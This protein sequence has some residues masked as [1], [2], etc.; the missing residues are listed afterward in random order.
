MQGPFAGSIPS[1]K[2]L[3]DTGEV[4]LAL[5][6]N[7]EPLSRDHG[8]PVRA[9]VPGYNAAR[10]VK[11]GF[12]GLWGCGAVGLWGCGAVELWGCMQSVSCWL[13]SHGPQQRQ[14]GGNV[15]RGTR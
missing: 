8:F 15:A 3:S 10:S 11:V 13:W 7:G 5:E 2:A 4:L 9:V 1:A 14:D 12:A 6:M